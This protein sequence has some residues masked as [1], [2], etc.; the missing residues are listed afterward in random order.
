MEFENIGGNCISVISE[1]IPDYIS[2]ALVSRQFRDSWVNE[3]K[4]S[5]KLLQRYVKNGNLDMV[6]FYIKNGCP[7]RWKKHICILAADN[8]HLEIL[9]WAR[10]EGCQWSKWICWLAAGKGHLET[11][12]WAISEGCQLDKWI[13]IYAACNGHLETLKWARSQGCPWDEQ[14]C[15]YAASNGHLETLKWARSQGCPWDVETCTNAALGGHM[16][17]LKWA[18]QTCAYLQQIK[19]L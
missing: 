8:G 13:C 9:K 18:R 12:K 11:L 5:R 19:K 10:S 7:L 6:K 1:Y 3:K 2:F 16:E 17:T 15:S 14:V 4:T